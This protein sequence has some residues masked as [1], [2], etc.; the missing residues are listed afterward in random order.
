MQRL[1]SSQSAPVA[2]SPFGLWE[3]N[4]RH[5]LGYISTIVDL[6]KSQ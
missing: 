5:G 1:P 2:V 4:S 3:E 6:Q